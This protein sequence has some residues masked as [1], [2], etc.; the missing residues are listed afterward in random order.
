MEDQ[1]VQQWR[2]AKQQQQ[3]A[4]KYRRIAGVVITF[5]G[6]LMVL[7]GM[8]IGEIPT[9]PWPIWGIALQAGWIILGGVVAIFGY[10]SAIDD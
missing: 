10:R 3:R 2:K 5:L 7:I 8:S 4:I 6:I 9:D 1:T